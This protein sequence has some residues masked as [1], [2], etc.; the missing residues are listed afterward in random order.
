MIK[1]IATVIIPAK[2][3]PHLLERAISSVL[4][5]DN[6]QDVEIIVIDDGSSPPLVPSGLRAQDKIIRQELSIGAAKAR[7][8]GINE[9][10]ADL[11]YL[12]DSDDYFIKRDYLGDKSDIS[13]NDIGFCDILSQGYISAYPQLVGRLEFFP[14]VFHRHKHIC[15]TSSLVFLKSSGLRF[16]PN[17]PKHQDWD[18]V[19]TQGIINGFRVRRLPGTIF[20][21]RSDT[22]SVSRLQSSSRSLQWLNKLR[23][24]NLLSEQ[25]D[26]TV[27]FNL[28]ARTDY[29]TVVRL[30]QRALRELLLG[31]TS[32]DEIARI[33]A[34]RML[35]KRTV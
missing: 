3:R 15:Q 10:G 28:L 23:E 31:R 25:E 2:G 9:A 22:H 7:N 6:S 21:D 17:L 34:R 12:L 4:S 35:S 16:D 30:F 24:M 20:F 19:F 1:P 18:F 5:Q 14:F 11:I 33:F 27:E 29:F 13:V 32:L 8:V 26:E